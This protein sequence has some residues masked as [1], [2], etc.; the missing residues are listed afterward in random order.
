MWFIPLIVGI[1]TASVGIILSIPT[2][3]TVMWAK[4]L[5]VP[6]RFW[7]SEHQVRARCMLAHNKYVQE[8][9]ADK[10]ETEAEI[11]RKYV[12]AVSGEAGEAAGKF[13]W[14]I[15]Y[16]APS[17]SVVVSISC[18]GE[19]TLSILMDKTQ[20]DEAVNGLIYSKKLIKP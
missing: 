4:Q 7:E 20:C 2:H 15:Y 9:T 16:H 10:P 18:V 17:N 19:T 12:K 14:R 6:W 3:K 5:N 8:R 11:D 1:L 13:S